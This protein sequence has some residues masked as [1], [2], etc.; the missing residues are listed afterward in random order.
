MHILIVCSGNKGKVSPFIIDQ[1]NAIQTHAIK[2]SYFIISGKGKL[3][4]LTNFF[5]LKN[6]INENKYTLIHAHYGLS[7]LLSVMQRKLPV[8]ITFHGSDVNLKKNLIL[9][10]IAARLSFHNIIVESSFKEKLNC[11]NCSLIP[12]G[13][14]FQTFFPISYT[15]ARNKYNFGNSENLILFASSFN[16]LIK[17]YPLAKR[18]VEISSTKPKL[19]ELKNY[20][21]SEV[22]LLMNACDLLILTSLS[23]GSP[24]VVKEA[25]ACNLPV[26]STPVGDVPIMSKNIDGIKII[27]YNAEEVAMEIDKFFTN[28]KRVSN[29]DKLMAYDNMYIA[30]QIIE[31]YKTAKK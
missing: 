22:C 12:C 3:G 27:S 5:R 13:I 30:K 11:K 28:K 4:Y 15:Q 8:V 2:C 18:A 17:N 14:D 25:L 29:S 21:R 19:I 31:I 23:E 20:N 9:S 10:K 24:Q 6:I 26:F 1:V 7:G 16:N